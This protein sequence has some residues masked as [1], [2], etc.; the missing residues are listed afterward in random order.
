VLAAGAIPLDVLEANVAA[1]IDANRPAE[2]RP[3][4]AN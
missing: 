4:A 3:E 2:K 1:Y